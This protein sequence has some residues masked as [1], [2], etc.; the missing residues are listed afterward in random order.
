MPIKPRE[1][2][3][4]EVKHLGMGT[5]NI[6]GVKGLYIRKTHTQSLFIFRYTDKFGRHDFSLGN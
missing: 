6:G 5:F 3:A 1:M 2:T 4:L